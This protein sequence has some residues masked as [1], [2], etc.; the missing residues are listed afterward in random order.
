MTSWYLAHYHS[1]ISHVSTVLL[2]IYVAFTLLLSLSSI[3]GLAGAIRHKSKWVKIYAELI[4]MNWFIGLGLGIGHI[5]KTWKNRKQ[6]LEMCKE[7][8]DKAVKEEDAV[9]AYKATDGCEKV[10]LRAV[11]QMMN[12]HCGR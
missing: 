7:S 6:L 10:S 1:T 11:E 3:L 4:C 9:A 12:M 8:M 5:V 2:S